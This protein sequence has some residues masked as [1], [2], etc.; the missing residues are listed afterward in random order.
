MTAARLLLCAMILTAAAAPASYADDC[1]P[2]DAAR[3]RDA[4]RAFLNVPAAVP[5]ELVASERVG[6]SCYD[7][8]LFETLDTRQIRES[9]LYLSPDREYLA[10]DVVAVRDEGDAPN[11]GPADPLAGAAPD[12]PVRGDS[13]AQLTLVDFSDFQCPYCSGAANI[14][15]ELTAADSNVKVV[16]RHMPLPIHPWALHA[17]RASAC[18]RGE[19]FWKLHDFYFE[20]QRELTAENVAAKTREYLSGLDSFDIA[21]FDECVAGSASLEAVRRDVRAAALLGVNGTP[22]I[23]ANGRRIRPSGSVDAFR[24]EIEAATG[25][26]VRAPQ[27]NTTYMVFLRPTG[28]SSSPEI[29]SRSASFLAQLKKEGELLNAGHARAADDAAG[30]EILTVRATD[31][32]AALKLISRSPLVTAGIMKAEV[33]EYQPAD[34]PVVR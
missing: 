16:F 13:R 33:V 31:A 27:R 6:T 12:S 18:A 2:V 9:I 24:K 25:I 14:L 34:H 4:A 17:A 28:R 8:L 22:T 30:F 21:A 10:R 3:V 29:D 5:L 23:Y 11:A 19:N 7:R 26:S 15:A 1:A 32:G 20:K